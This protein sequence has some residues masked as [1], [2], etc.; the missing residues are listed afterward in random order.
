MARPP[1][2]KPVGRRSATLDGLGDQQRDQAEQQCASQAVLG[3]QRAPLGRLEPTALD[4]HG[5]VVGTPRHSRRANPSRKATAAG[6]RR[7][8]RPRLAARPYRWTDDRSLQAIIER[9]LEPNRAMI[10]ATVASWARSRAGSAYAKA[11]PSGPKPA[12]GQRRGTS[13]AITARGALQLAMRP[14][15]SAALR[16][17]WSPSKLGRPQVGMA[18][19][20]AC[21]HGWPAHQTFRWCPRCCGLITRDHP[22]GQGGWSEAD[23]I[24]DAP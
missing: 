19:S 17:F 11:A 9:R 5:A 18:V 20:P 4:R 16:R 23:G 22:A 2:A 3:S 21:S 8:A 1:P 15:D 10:T 12:R 24:N 14:V 6:S 7:P 13:R